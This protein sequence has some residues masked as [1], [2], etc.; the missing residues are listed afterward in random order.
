MADTDNLRTAS[1]YINNQL[2]SRGLL[3][4]G[5]TIDFADPMSGG[6][7]SD[8]MSR[9]MGVVNDLILRRDRDAEHREALS[10]TLRTLRAEN[11]HQTNHLQRECDA[12]A[13][14]QRRLQTAEAAS[15]AQRAQL[16][17]AES[18]IHKLKDDA[19]RTKA[20]VA[21][22]RGACANEV[23]KRDRQIEALKKAVLDAGRARGERRGTAVTSITVTGEMGGDGNEG[24]AAAGLE[25]GATACDD[26]DLRQESNSF[27]AELAKGLSAD[28][29]AL[30]ALVRRVESNLKDMSGYE[31]TPTAESNNAQASLLPGAVED[32]ETELEAVLQ[33]LRTILT[34]PSFVPIEEVMVRD[35]EIHRLREGWEKM[36]TRWKEAVHLIDG[37]RRRMA[38]SGKSVNMEE[39]KMGLRL[40][41]VRVRH[42]AETAQGLGLR[43]APINFNLRSVQEEEEDDEE[44]KEEQREEKSSA[45]MIPSPAESL[46]LVP[47]P[48]YEDLAEDDD[49]DDSDSDSES[50][51]FEDEVD[52]H[53]LDVSEPNVQILEQSMMMETLDSSP[54]PEPPQLSP[55]KDS[56][57]AGNRRRP[58][59]S[60]SRK[61]PGDFSAITEENTYDP[62]SAVEEAPP[63]PPARVAKKAEP[64]QRQT[65][66]ATRPKPQEM[67]S[68]PNS[69]A[70]YASTTSTTTEKSIKLVKSDASAPTSGTKAA[71]PPP[72][73]KR[74]TAK[75]AEQ[76]QQQ[77]QQPSS[78]RPTRPAT[79]MAT[80][81]PTRAAAAAA[82]ASRAVTSNRETKTHAPSKSLP[83][84]QIQETTTSTQPKRGAGAKEMPPPPVPTRA[85]RQTAATPSKMAI[86]VPP[87]SSSRLPLPR[88]ANANGVPQSPLTMATI[89]AKLAASEREADAARVRAK[90]KAAR[91]GRGGL[92]AAA[93]AAAAAGT[94]PASRTASNGTTKSADDSE[95]G[96]ASV[97][98]IDSGVEPV[99]RM[100]AGGARSPLPEL[101]V[102][103]GSEDK[104]SSTGSTVRAVVDKPQDLSPRKRGRRAE[105]VASRRRSTLNAWELKTLISGEVAVSPSRGS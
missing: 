70:S 27:L 46:H 79:S 35:E 60:R 38:S 8:T 97:R 76:Q 21:Q 57:T 25:Q 99:R 91:L 105:K 39:L 44:L 43:V 94:A 51:I 90:L 1:L 62:A 16:S 58:E 87:P 11:L 18:T 34:N 104:G 61:R 22:T 53:D 32:L 64:R 95:Q 96:G 28:N 29:E 5:S 67:P 47:A 10:Q 26:Y 98:S 50:S 19:A 40:S 103:G 24:Q 86:V 17:Q 83:E 30:M 77:Q 37:W 9:I 88:T 73:K 85:T 66:A 93:A 63:K 6:D 54:L 42:V 74:N 13:D 23:R 52:I 89:Q 68:R 48:G 80:T 65:A 14:A 78:R 59:P 4:D 7:L 92:G 56:E 36:E 2:L 82:A 75:T 55:L 100:A 20:L 33:H 31:G 41:P 15:Q 84:Q 81:R 72:A 69:A 101:A 71:Q 12:H 3:R 45:H 102:S 49:N